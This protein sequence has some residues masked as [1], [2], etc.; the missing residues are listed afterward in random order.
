MSNSEAG[1]P[2]LFWY[3]I[4]GGNVYAYV[5]LIKKKCLQIWTWDY[6]VC[7]FCFSRERTYSAAKNTFG[8]SLGRDNASSGCQWLSSSLWENTGWKQLQ[9]RLYFGSQSRKGWPSIMG[10][11]W[12]GE[13]EVSSHSSFPIRKQKGRISMILPSPFLFHLESCPKS[14]SSLS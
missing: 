8:I 6:K 14:L 10:K 7:K 4:C 5:S 9:K 1:S 13:Q 12:Q 11:S 2:T 3:R